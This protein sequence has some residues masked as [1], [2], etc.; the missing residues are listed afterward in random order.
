MGHPLAI[1]QVLMGTVYL[2]QAFLVPAIW[3]RSF[4]DD[5][6]DLGTLP[7]FLV[8]TGA[9]VAGVDPIVWTKFLYRL[10]LW[11]LAFVAFLLPGLRLFAEAAGKQ[12][13]TR[14]RFV[15]STVSLILLHVFACCAQGI[16]DLSVHLL[17]AWLDAV[18]M[19]CVVALERF[20][21]RIG[22]IR[23]EWDARADLIFVGGGSLL[24]IMIAS[25][26]LLELASAPAGGALILIVFSATGRFSYRPLWTED[27]ST[28]G[29]IGFFLFQE[30]GRSLP[31]SFLV[32][33]AFASL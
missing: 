11:S 23:A 20:H 5:Q 15:E 24:V 21:E 13:L 25:I 26:V 30:F 32:W 17:L 9:P 22:P 12:R 4:T 31:D 1:L 14:I 27:R 2:V 7:I 19:F 8:S 18:C 10:P 16:L 6:R 29:S 28:C 33:I 3:F